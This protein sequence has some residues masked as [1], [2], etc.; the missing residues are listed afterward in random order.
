VSAWL[1][2][3]SPLVG[4]C[5]AVVLFLVI[6]PDRPPGLM[7]LRII[8]LHTVIVGT[9]ALG[10]TV[11]IVCGGIDL[12]V[13]SA[14]ALASVVAAK[15][16]KGGG[17]PG[18]ALLA[19]VAAGGL[20]GLYNGVLITGLRLPPFIATLGTLG[21]FRGAAKWLSDK[22][23]VSASPG[24]M[25]GWVQLVPAKAWMVV[26]PAVWVL[27]G[28][29]LLTSAMLHWTVFGRRLTAIGSNEEAARRAGVPIRRTKVF[30]YI[31]GG[32]FAGMAG[33]ILFARLTQG[34]PTAAAGLELEVIAAVVIG[35]ASLSGGTGSVAGACA[36]A[37]L[38]AFLK[39]RCTV[40]GWE[41][42]IQE[43]VVGH[44]IIAAVALDRWRRMRGAA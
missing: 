22:G 29:S 13:G 14:A 37:V 44:I 34:D 9:A 4:L 27:A 42:Y 6:A 21:F 26:A 39:N 10:M 31:A 1:T 3:L 24:W 36:G 19:A 18:E 41:N 32:L 12:S 28:L 43:I 35:G 16:A 20:C 8:A 15:V 33:A 25:E 7:D 11:V 23:P 2:R 40:L 30:V 38:M 17:S 5:A